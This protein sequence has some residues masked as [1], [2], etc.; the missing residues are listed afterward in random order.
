M[1]RPG[2]LLRLTHE[3]ISLPGSFI[4]TRSH[5]A[6]R[7]TS[8]KNRRQF[9]ENQF[10]LVKHEN[11]LAWLARVHDKNSINKALWKWSGR[12]FS[13][14][15]STIMTELGVKACNFTPA[16]LRPGGA[17]MYFNQGVHS[18]TLRFMGRWTVEKSLEHYIQ[19]AMATQIMN[20]LDE[21]AVLRLRKLAHLCLKC[22]LAADVVIKAL[23]PLPS[24]KASTADLACWCDR[25]VSLV[26]D[27]RPVRTAQ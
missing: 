3:D 7:I 24:R 25:F 15:F 18:S 20:R 27:A 23:E 17:T 1:L 9:G 10:V 4:M 14:K 13:L 5:G 12:E 19:L 26:E 22:L 6:L 21:S 16:S 2:E 8:P 11:T